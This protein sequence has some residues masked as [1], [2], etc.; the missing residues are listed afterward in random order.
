MATVGGGGTGGQ[1]L[2]FVSRRERGN[3]GPEY[4]V[5][6]VTLCI[7]GSGAGV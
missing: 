1:N 6:G 4:L 3:K 2:L 7:G 5:P